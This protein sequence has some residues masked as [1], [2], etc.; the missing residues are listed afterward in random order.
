M[1]IYKFL[2]ALVIL[3]LSSCTSKKGYSDLDLLYSDFVEILKSSN[4]RDLKNFCYKI[5]PDDRTFEYMNRNNFSYHRI[6]E[7]LV[8]RNIKPS[9]LGEQYYEHVQDFKQELIRKNQLKDLKYIGREIE[10]VAY[11]PGLDT[12]GTETHILMESRGDTI[13]YQ[14]GDIVRIDGS[15]KSFTFPM[16]GK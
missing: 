8:E 2:F 6:P 13:K 7:A 15:W 9:Y 14:L 1:Q 11:V 10:G 3:S 4:T 5:T 16:L 12:Y